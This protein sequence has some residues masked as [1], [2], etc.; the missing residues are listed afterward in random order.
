[1][2]VLSR[3]ALLAAAYC[4]VP[5]CTPADGGSED[6]PPLVIGGDGGV[7]LDAQP[8]DAEPDAAPDAIVDMMLPPPPV[9]AICNPGTAYSA[10]T[11]MFA[12][13]TVEWKLEQIGVQATRLSVGDIDGDGWADVM[14][15][16]GGRRSDILVEDAEARR[17]HHWLLR[18]EG[19]LF[20]DVTETSGVLATRGEYPLPLG[21]PIE[22]ATFGDV[23]NDGDLDLYTGLDTRMPVEI[24]REG[25]DPIRVV[26]R[27]ELLINDGEGGFTLAAEDHPLRRLGGEDVPSGAALVDFDRDGHLDLWMSQGGLGASMQDLLWRGDGAGGFADVTGAVGLRTVEWAV[28]EDIN[29][30]EG[31]TTAWSAAACD[32]NNDGTPELLA[33][34]YGRAPN[35]LWQGVE[36]DG[37]FSFENRSVASGYAYDDNQRWQDDQFARCYCAANRNAPDCADVPAPNVQCQD[38]WNHNYGREPFRLGGNSGATVCADLNNDGWLD[39][40]TTEIKHWWAGQAADGS[41]PLVNT[42]EADVR[43]VRPG[44]ENVGTQLSHPQFNW[45]EGHI[46]AGYL[47][48]DNDG[49]QDIYIGGTD[50]AGNRGLLYRNTSEWGGAL[51]FRAV[52]VEDF[53]EHNRSHGMAVADFDRDGDL[54]L[55]VGHSR[56][57]CDANAPNNCYPTAQARF[58]E[59]I[60]GQ[61]GNW[62][63][64]DL[65]G[66]EGT[67]SLAFGARVEVRTEAGLQVQE[68]GGGY[69]HFGAQRD[70]ILHFGLGEACEAVVSI[71]WPDGDLTTEHLRLGSGYRYLVRQGQPAEVAPR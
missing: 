36:E 51:R 55:I 15:R 40:Y 28:I 54:D 25:A 6:P 24:A 65:R 43:F 9:E 41:E 19:D 48:V 33:A 11:A 26:E 3:A 14:A 31:H 68:V 39:L 49:R 5:A 69:G 18:N 53:F 8:A 34:S 17:Q 22:V 42:G 20:V 71:R 52:P 59:N 13:R 21:R 66:A 1:M 44:N 35:H 47:D 27:S 23:D 29:Q 4:L 38:N 64:L 70:R 62:L 32:L 7:E 16:R 58:F 56:A 12:E 45:D 2:S 63:Q 57:R 37:A 60:L 61:D 10:G 30:A 46:T 67:N 50:Y